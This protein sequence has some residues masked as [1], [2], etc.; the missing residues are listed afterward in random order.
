MNIKINMA[1]LKKGD[2]FEKYKLNLWALRNKQQ[3]ASFT[4]CV[5]LQSKIDDLKRGFK[6]D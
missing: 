1:L 2:K 6:N 5:L 4:Y 3:N